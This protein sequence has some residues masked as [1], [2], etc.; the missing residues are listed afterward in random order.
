MESITKSNNNFDPEKNK[1]TI[2]EKSTVNTLN[3]M[4]PKNGTRKVQLLFVDSS[5]P[6]NS[7]D[8]H[9]EIE[10]SYSTIK[11]ALNG[12]SKNELTIDAVVVGSSDDFSQI[13]TL[14]KMT[15]QRDLPLI[16]YTSFFDQKAKDMAMKLGVDDYFYGSM[17]YTLASR[18]K[19]IQRLR[20]YK[21][22]WLKQEKEHKGKRDA[23]PTSWQFFQSRMIDVIISSIA[24]ILFLPVIFIIVVALEIESM[25]DHIFSNSKK[26]LGNRIYNLYQFI[27]L[28]ML[29]PLIVLITIPMKIRSREEHVFSTSKKVG[30]GWRIFDLYK[31]RTEV[32]NPYTNS[33]RSTQLGMFLMKSGLAEIPQL[34]NVLKGDMSLRG[35]KPLSTDEAV[36]LTKDQ[37][38]SQ[39]LT[40]PSIGSL[41]HAH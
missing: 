5:H 28:V 41:Q 15:T 36:K 34:I 2:M 14:R 13:V 40:Q 30:L 7:Y 37:S 35:N 9:H 19:F 16:L 1:T 23:G 26:A 11:E 6:C 39:F 25:E 33:K 18:I 27:I 4:V 12:M 29:S 21:I 10:F 20:E 38:A 22:Q 8:L 3:G 17:V 32:T 24:L 31:F